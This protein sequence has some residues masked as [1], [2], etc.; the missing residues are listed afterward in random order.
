MRDNTAINGG[1]SVDYR[2]IYGEVKLYIN[3]QLSIAFSGTTFDSIS[4]NSSSYPSATGRSLFTG[5]LDATL[6]D[7][8]GQ[9]CASVS[10]YGDGD[11]GTPGSAN[12]ACAGVQTLS[13]LSAG[14]LVITEVM[15]NPDQVSDHRGEWFELYNASGSDV[16]L[17]GLV[18]SSSSDSGFTLSGELVVG[19]GELVL[20][21]VRSNSAVNGG[22]SNVDAVYS[23]NEIKFTDVDSLSVGSSSTTLDSVAWG[24][25]YPVEAGRSLS[26][27]AGN[28]DASSNDSVANW[29][30]ATS[31]FGDGDRGALRDGEQQLPVT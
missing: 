4:L 28:L 25:I 16:D 1:V 8:S 2:Y 13:Q 7:S 20:F 26:L 12:D 6:N 27:D 24:S 23:I 3:D 22:I 5:A 31:S 11:L 15:H 18:V 21:A 14:D 30:A 19:A 10:S 29:C 9:W 17:S